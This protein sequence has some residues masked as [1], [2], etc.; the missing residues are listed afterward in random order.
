MKQNYNDIVSHHSS[1]IGLTHLEEMVI[2]TDPELPPVVTKPYPLP[3]KLHKFVKDK[4]ENLFKARLIKRSMSPYVTHV[5]V[6]PRKCKVRCTL[7]RNMK[8]SNRLLRI[9]QTDPQSRDIPSLI[10]RQ[11]SFN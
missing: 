6:F 8:I 3:L 5:I 4:I 11:S 9:K 10:E 1:N 2:E 7:S